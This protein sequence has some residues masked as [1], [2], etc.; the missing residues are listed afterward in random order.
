M[1]RNI[2]KGESMKKNKVALLL[3]AAMAVSSL[4][5]TAALAQDATDATVA[6]TAEESA[7]VDEEMP[8]EVEVKAETV[9][10]ET[11]AESTEEATTEATA[12]ATEEEVVE[13]ETEAIEDETKDEAK[14][15]GNTGWVKEDDNWF[16]YGAD[17]TKKT[18]WVQSLGK[19]YYLDPAEDGAMVTGWNEIGNYWYFMNPSGD[20]KTGWQVI[21]GDD[22]YFSPSSA[23][24]FTGWKQFGVHWFYFDPEE[25]EHGGIMS[26]GWKMIGEKEYYFNDGGIMVKGPR[27]ID[28]DMYLF[29]GK[30]GDLKSGWALYE[31][32]YYYAD[33]ENEDILTTGWKE[34]GGNWYS[35]DKNGAMQTGWQKISGFWFYF[36]PYGP[37]ATGWA[38]IGGTYYYFNESGI[39][40][41]GW[42]K[43]N[44]EW[45]YMTNNGAMVTGVYR[46]D[47]ILYFFH[48]SGALTKKQGWQ[49]TADGTEY[50]TYT[51][52]RVAVNTTIDGKTLNKDGVV[53]ND[54]DSIAQQ[55]SSPTNYLIVADRT[56]HI[57]G[58]YQ[59]SKGNWKRIKGYWRITTG[60][61]KTPTPAGE[62]WIRFKDSS[63]YG[64]EQF[65]Q[66]KAAWCSYCSGGFYIHSILYEKS[67]SN[68]IS[69][70]NTPVVDG[71]LGA[72][73]SHSCIRVT[74]ANAKWVYQNI[75]VDT[76]VVVYTH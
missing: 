68:N 61:N 29:D 71:E 64:W 28:G 31:G 39:M 7:P 70:S 35:F 14:L 19:W 63:P 30:N 38:N 37:M 23:Y 43:L 74:T 52:G 60:A 16:F 66:T 56:D 10:G 75:P 57:L 49:K 40:V 67:Y 20:A 12:V 5:A 9:E 51:N 18:G 33:P 26:T 50:Y 42:R 72:N 36:R 69:P 41:T 6:V 13:V 15:A 59:G 45:Y 54:P 65:S 1:L 3:A 24:L 4:P 73:L 58:V 62:H 32:K 17:E 46:A 2:K 76:K 47:N 55:Y 53:A 11:K 21:D 25:G 34:I 8:A 27:T 44:N 48:N 22:Y